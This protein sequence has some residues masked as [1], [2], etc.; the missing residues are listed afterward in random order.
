M[1]NLLLIIASGPC[2]DKGVKEFK[3]LNP[4]AYD[5]CCINATGLW[6]YGPFK[7]WVSAHAD[8]LL[9]W[10]NIKP[11]S[12]AELWSYRERAGVRHAYTR[13]DG[14]SS[15]FVAVQFGLFVWEYRRI[16]VAGAPLTGG[17][18]F[19]GYDRFLPAWEN[20][21]P[22]FLHRVRSMSGETAKILGKP[23]KDFVSVFDE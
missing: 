17:N 16:V 20:L 13:W 9:E 6:H 7:Y 12:R 19:G 3:A 10:A 11:N 8:K 14:G 5:T 21:N 15:T 1:N 22:E 18:K 23:D 2:R 4:D